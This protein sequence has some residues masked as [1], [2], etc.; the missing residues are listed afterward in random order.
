MKHWTIVTSPFVLFYVLGLT[1]QCP[2]NYYIKAFI[3]SFTFLLVNLGSRFCRISNDSSTMEQLPVSIYLATKWWLL[4]T[5]F[6]RIAPSVGWIFNTVFTLSSTALCYFF[7]RT[8]KNDPGTIV[9][10]LAEK[11]QTIKKLA[12]FGPGFEPEHFC[13]TCLLRRPI[14]SKHC[15][16]C[17]R[18]VARFDHHCPWVGN[19]IGVGNH[20]FFVY[21]LF[22]LAFSCVLFVTGAIHYW[23]YRCDFSGGVFSWSVAFT[24]DG[25]LSFTVFN[26]VL[27]TVWVVA[28]LICQL[29]QMLW[30]AMTTNERANS[31]RYKHFHRAT[32]QP[33][34]SGRC[35][36]LLHQQSHYISPFDL[37]LFFNMVDFFKLHKPLRVA[38]PSKKIDDIDWKEL[39]DMDSWLT[40][41]S[42]GS[43]FEADC[44]RVQLIP[45]NDGIV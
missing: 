23:S 34:P 45:Q 5:W 31:S 19:C 1:F 15:S 32:K 7:Y 39:F 13:S 40:A 33:V 30:L 37:G 25:W 12:E 26:A 29:Y 42:G 18:C 44:E 27:H 11:H 35:K 10:S 24:C 2:W 21:Y 4:V 22:W 16:A 14:R 3:L 43:A 9:T 41:K 28:I 8:W 20:H 36:Q 6:V 17:N 38:C